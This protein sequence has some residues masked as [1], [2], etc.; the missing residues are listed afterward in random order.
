LNTNTQGL[1]NELADQMLE[2]PLEVSIQMERQKENLEK[3]TESQLDPIKAK[4]VETE[5]KL[6]ESV[7]RQILAPEARGT[8]RPSPPPSAGPT[9]GPARPEAIEMSSGLVDGTASCIHQPTICH[10]VAS[11]NNVNDVNVHANPTANVSLS[12]Y[13]T[14]TL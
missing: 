13:L 6:R 2:H 8:M 12:G 14:N 3:L 7:D 9:V 5:S 10:T 4:F 1:I 11:D